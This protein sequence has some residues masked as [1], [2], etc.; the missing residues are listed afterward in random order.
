MK[1]KLSFYA[2]LIAAFSLVL[3]IFY[4]PKWQKA[5]TEATIS[6]DVSGYYLYLPAIF[7]YK[8]VKKLEFL[9][10]ITRKY[11][12]DP[13]MD[14]AFQHSNGNK[15]MKYSLGQAVSFSPF[16]FIAH[17]WASIDSRYPADGF[18]FPYQFMIS[19]GSLLVAF[20]GIWFLR[21]VLLRFF[22][23]EV[24]AFTLLVTVLATNYFDYASI[25]GAMTHNYVFTIYSLLIF[26]TIK[27]YE[28]PTFTRAG[29]I[30]FLVGLAALTRPTE[31]IS[32]LI[33][34]LWGFEGIS[35]KGISRKLQFVFKENLLKIIFAGIVCGLVGSLQL[36]YWKIAGGEW[37]IYSYED[38]GFS[39]W[40]PHLLNGFFAYNNGW[41]VYTPAMAFA[42]VGFIPLLFKSAKLFLPV[43]VFS[44]LFI[45]ITF[46]WDI[47]WYGGSLGQRAMVQAYPVLAISLAALIEWV[48]KT[49]K[50]L[51]Y[52]LVIVFSLFVYYNFWLTYQAHYGGLYLAGQMTGSFF[53]KTLGKYEVPRDVFKFLDTD[54][55]YPGNPKKEILLY[56]NDFEN[57]SALLSCDLPPINGNYSYCLNK[58]NQFTP[59]YFA[60]LQSGTSNWVRGEATVWSPTREYDIWKMALFIIRLYDQDKEVKAKFIK[61]YRLLHANETRK[62]NVDIK[63]PDNIPVDKVGVFFWNFESSNTI[64]VDDVKIKQLQ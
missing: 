26:F 36:I 57:D 9:E 48:W 62:I 1:N 28:R 24:V 54:E 23:D 20:L 13:N 10:E 58:E 6:W 21:K 47:W 15:I 44:G 22:R 55:E 25:T 4:Y 34:L 52:L 38:Q 42:L 14:Q 39:W 64:L 41:L 19:F 63:L 51:K 2:F 27:F 61:V 56:E 49:S 53:W 50:I 16:F 31:I 11:S 46:A 33:P 60:S 7:I 8:D 35:V 37:I 18:S 43:F 3:A 12:P 17:A 5:E 29:T 59:I 40:R 45:Y 32:C 30:G